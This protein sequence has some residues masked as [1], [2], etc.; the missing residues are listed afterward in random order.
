MRPGQ[1]FQFGDQFSMAP[2]AELRV[3]AIL[4]R[5]QSQLL[6]PGGRVAREVQVPQVIER[7]SSPELETGPKRTRSSRAIAT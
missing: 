2:E 5:L 1:F 4:H 7:C 6:E 3:A